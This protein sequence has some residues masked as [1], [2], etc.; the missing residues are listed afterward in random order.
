MIKELNV[1]C[2]CGDDKV[3]IKLN[4]YM[5]VYDLMKQKGDEFGSQEGLLPREGEIT[6]V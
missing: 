5:G 6:F 1:F 2:F 4:I 3:E